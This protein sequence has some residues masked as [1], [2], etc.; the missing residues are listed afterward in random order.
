MAVKMSKKKP[1]S[2]KTR[3]WDGSNY[4]IAPKTKLGYARVILQQPDGKNKQIMR[5]TKNLTRRTNCRRNSRRS[6]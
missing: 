6:W 2:D 4:W 5:R 1:K 3:K